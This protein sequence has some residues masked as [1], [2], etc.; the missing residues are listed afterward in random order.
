MQH[1]DEFIEN[2]T[3]GKALDSNFWQD[4]IKF[5]NFIN[6]LYYFFSSKGWKIATGK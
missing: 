4:I 5:T 2:Y 6:N 3:T 1:S